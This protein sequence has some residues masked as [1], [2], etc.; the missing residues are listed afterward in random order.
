MVEMRH[1]DSAQEKLDL[2]NQNPQARLLTAGEMADYV[3]KARNWPSD[4][5]RKGRLISVRHAGETYYPAFQI[6][7]VHRETWEWVSTMAGILENEGTTGRSFT[8]WAATPSPRFDGD[9]PAMHTGDPDF[10]TKAAADLA[11]L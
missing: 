7:T 4:S 1:K 3:D 10:M 9:T 11:E 2:L 8:L 6:D 5:A